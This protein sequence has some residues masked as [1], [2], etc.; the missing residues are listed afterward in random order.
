MKPTMIW[1]EYTPIAGKKK[2]SKEYTPVP[3]EIKKQ[4]DIDTFIRVNVI[5]QYRCED[6]D[7]DDVEYKKAE[8]VPIPIVLA[9]IEQATRRVNALMKDI[10]EL[11]NLA[12]AGGKQ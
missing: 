9:W 10:T 2:L 7:C 6:K 5:G 3:I 4:K 11:T 1:Y 12:K 8:A